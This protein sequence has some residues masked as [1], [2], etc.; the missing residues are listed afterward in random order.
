MFVSL[1]NK[2]RS[3]ER[4]SNYTHGNYRRVRQCIVLMKNDTLVN[5][6][7]C[8]TLD[9][10]W[11][12]FTRSVIACLQVVYPQPTISKS[13]R[14]YLLSFYW[15]DCCLDSD[16]EWRIYVLL[17]VTNHHRKLLGSKELQIVYLVGYQE[18]SCRSQI[19]GDDGMDPL[20][21]DSYLSYAQYTTMSLAMDSVHVSLGTFF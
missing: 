4:E 2:W 20:L 12:C 10:L 6:P 13:R 16:W 11:S 8:L 15:S 3:R 5:Y 7:Q 18:P 1:G 14:Q 9:S 19:L 17:F 21:G